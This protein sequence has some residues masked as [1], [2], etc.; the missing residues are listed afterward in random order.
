MVSGSCIDWEN[1]KKQRNICSK[2][3]HK[4]K[5]EFYSGLDI[6]T[7]DNNKKFWKTFKPL[8]S[9]KYEAGGGKIILVEN[10]TITPD[11]TIT[12]IFN[13][14]FVNITKSLNL[15]DFCHTCK[16]GFIKSS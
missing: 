14:Y 6:S 8:L 1:Y 4:T 7:I 9:E 2:L 11:E 3:N 12:N 10:E 5:C 13:D 15:T 16:Q